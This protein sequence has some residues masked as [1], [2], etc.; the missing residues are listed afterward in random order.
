[1]PLPTARMALLFL[2][3]M[4]LALPGCR[5]RSESQPQNELESQPQTRAATQASLD[6]P[7]VQKRTVTGEP[8]LH[9]GETLDPAQRR[10]VAEL[11]AL[12][13]QY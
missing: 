13:A 7:A 10:Q 9:D 5:R 2:A 11:T 6:V 1:M 3:C 12:I 8:V 4:A